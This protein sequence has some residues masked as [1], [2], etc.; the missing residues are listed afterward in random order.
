MNDDIEF[1]DYISKTQKK[2]E[3]EGLQK[4]GEKLVKLAPEHLKGME[5]PEELKAAIRFAKTIKSNGAYKRQMQFIGTLMRHIETEPIQGALDH[6]EAGNHKKALQFKAI[7]TWR[8]QLI[9]GD[10]ALLEQ[11]IQDCPG[12]ERQKL[13]QLVRQAKKEVGNN[14]PPKAVKSLFRYLTEIKIKK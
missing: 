8:D 2:R 10:N 4:I 6:I 1:D 7:E 11:I 13:S 12:A 9:A 5:L 14:K 3:A